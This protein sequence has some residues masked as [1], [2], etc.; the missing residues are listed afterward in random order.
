MTAA[1]RELLRRAR[2]VRVFV[3]ETTGVAATGRLLI[4]RLALAGSTFAVVESTDGTAA[5]REVNERFAKSP[6][7][8]TLESEFKDVVKEIFHAGGEVQKVLE[9]DTGTSQEWVVRGFTSAGTEG[10]RYR[11]VV[12]YL[13]V[14]QW[15]AGERLSFELLDSE[16]KGIHWSFTPTAFSDWREVRVDVDRKR[17]TL[18]DATPSG[19]SVSVDHHDSL[20]QFRVRSDGGDASNALVYVDELHMASPIG[21]LGAAVSVDTELRVPG[22][23]V[24]IRGVP[25]VSDLRVREIAST[26]TPG[27]SPLYGRP[28]GAW[29][30]SSRT[31]VGMSLP[32]SRLD[33]HFVA[34]WTDAEATLGGGH[35]LLTSVGPLSVSDTFDLRAPGSDATFDRESRLRLSP[36]PGTAADASARAS[37]D[38]DRLTQEW[39][40]SLTVSAGGWHGSLVSDFSLSTLDYEHSEEGYFDAWIMGYR[41]FAPEQA[42]PLERTSRAA[43]EVALLP[44]PVGVTLQVEPSATSRDSGAGREQLNGLTARLAIPWE[45]GN[46]GTILTAAY[47][48]QMETS[49][50]LAGPGGFLDDWRMFAEGLAE[51][52]YVYSGVPLWELYSDDGGFRSASASVTSALYAPELQVEVTRRPG[53]QIRHLVLPTRMLAVVGRSLQKEGALTSDRNRYSLAYQTNAINLFGRLGSHPTFTFYDLDEIA[54]GITLSLDVDGSGDLDSGDLQLDSLVGMESSGGNQVTVSNRFSLTGEGFDEAANTS[55]ASYTWFVRPEGGV[56]LPLL[57][58]DIT[59]EAFWAHDEALEVTATS[60]T[61]PITALVRHRSEIRIPEHGHVAATLAIGADFE[62]YTGGDRAGVDPPARG[63]GRDRGA[64]PLRLRRAEARR[65]PGRPRSRAGPRAV[66]RDGG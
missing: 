39:S 32:A 56:R 64:D 62:K 4:D 6:P 27:F 20:V 35:S 23:L 48:R 42:S 51:Q 50:P 40:G 54:N 61:R 38:D 63:A 25:V 37:A 60:G 5:A 17:L 18:N 41:F 55:Q 3:R 1:E 66:G 9:I 22:P 26:V 10:A 43:A 44:R 46:R 16:G 29:G 45:I 13:R 34:D 65:Q 8:R 49:V 24:R 7:A 11:E 21:S 31:E 52:S 36:L 33:A 57:G 19:A 28:A 59:R 14:P 12:H 15:N 53:S 47:Q 2:A 58:Q 30:G